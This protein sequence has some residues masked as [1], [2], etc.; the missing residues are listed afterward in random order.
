MGRHSFGSVLVNRNS[1]TDLKVYADNEITGPAVFSAPG[2]SLPGGGNPSHALTASGLVSTRGAEF[3]LAAG[4]EL[5]Q[6][7][8]VP[9][10]AIRTSGKLDPAIPATCFG[11]GRRRYETS[12]NRADFSGRRCAVGH[13]PVDSG[14]LRPVSGPSRY[15]R[16]S[17]RRR[18]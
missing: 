12:P 14:E 18:L 11:C 10:S 17:W 3:F 9:G 8:T 1:L 5:A 13:G 4:G 2:G 16:C 7:T 15:L 6:G